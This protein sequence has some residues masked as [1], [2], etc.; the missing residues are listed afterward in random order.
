MWGVRACSCAGNRS[1]SWRHCATA[2]AVLLKA[3]S[4]TAGPVPAVIDMTGR[5][6]AARAVA[7]DTA[8]GGAAPGEAAAAPCGAGASDLLSILMRASCDQKPFGYFAR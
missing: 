2:L 7:G 5:D 4:C 6:G 3:P 8:T 1:E